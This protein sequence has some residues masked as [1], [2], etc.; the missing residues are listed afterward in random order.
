MNQ[1]G[2][3]DERVLFI[4]IRPQESAANV[5]SRAAEQRA[6]RMPIS[7]TG[8]ISATLT[9]GPRIFRQAPLRSFLLIKRANKK[10]APP[11]S[12]IGLF[13]AP[14]LI[15][16]TA[17]AGRDWIAAVAGFRSDS[18]RRPNWRRESRAWPPRWMNIKWGRGPF[19]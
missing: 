15:A 7:T 2:R 9:I 1:D 10:L 13:M 5:R 12:P 11:D 4:V 18:R 8:A 16:L 19:A 3:T 17:A 14:S 6:C